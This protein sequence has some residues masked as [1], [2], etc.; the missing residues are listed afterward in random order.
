[1]RWGTTKE[2]YETWR[3]WFAWHPVMIENGQWV[4]LET[5]E[6][7]FKPMDMLVVGGSCW[8]YREINNGRP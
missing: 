6:R 3:P 1:M 4:W 7:K 2:E 8:D 5:V